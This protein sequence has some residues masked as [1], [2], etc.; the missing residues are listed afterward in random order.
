MLFKIQRIQKNQTQKSQEVNDAI[1]ILERKSNLLM[2]LSDRKEMRISNT[3]GNRI[4]LVEV[5]CIW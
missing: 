3:K 2:L 5:L 4:G 1:I